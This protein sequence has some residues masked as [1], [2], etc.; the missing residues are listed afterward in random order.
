MVAYGE[1]RWG[2]GESENFNTY[3]RK[4]KA[5]VKRETSDGDSIFKQK[6]IFILLVDFQFSVRLGKN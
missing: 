4:E 3:L 5:K 1:W 2:Q 6:Q